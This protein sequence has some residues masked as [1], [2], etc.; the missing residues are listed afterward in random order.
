MLPAYPV[1]T[2]AVLTAATGRNRVAVTNGIRDLEAAGVLV[3]L[4]GGRWNRAWEAEV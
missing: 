3:P 2:I 1:A 4:G